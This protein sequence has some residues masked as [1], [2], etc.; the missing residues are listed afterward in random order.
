MNGI[1]L[2]GK[3]LETACESCQG[4]CPA[5]YN[6]GTITLRSGITVDKVMRAT[7][8]VCGSVLQIAHQSAHK[9]AEKKNRYIKRNLRLSQSLKDFAELKLLEYTGESRGAVEILIRAALQA[10]VRSAQNRETILIRLRSLEDPILE[11]PSDTP[12]TI[13]LTPELDA[14][15]QN[16]SRSLKSSTRSATF[17][18]LIVLSDAEP[19]IQ[20]ELKVL[21]WVRI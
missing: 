2:P 17:R 11:L 7:C 13:L 4:F 20:S 9:I 19:T 6:Y 3:K 8:D 15:A 18:K 5:T 10:V 12:E 16:L 14:E 1:I 21:S